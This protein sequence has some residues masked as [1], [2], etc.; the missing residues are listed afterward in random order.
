MAYERSSPALLEE[1]EDEDCDTE[2]HVNHQ[3]GF[4]L[5]Q[6]ARVD[7]FVNHQLGF[8]LNQ[9]ARVDPF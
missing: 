2:T 7:P 9:V 8:I 6:V 1:N 5:N 4:I 3:L